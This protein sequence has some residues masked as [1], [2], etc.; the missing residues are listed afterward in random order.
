MDG[1]ET[2]AIY[3]DITALAFMDVMLIYLAVMLY[4]Y[5]WKN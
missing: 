1:I 5:L 3:Y 4:K 2:N